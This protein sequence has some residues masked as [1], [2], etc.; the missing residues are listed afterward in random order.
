MARRPTSPAKASPTRSRSL[1][2]SGLMLEHVGRLD[3]AQR[4]RSAIDDVIIKDNMRTGDMGGRAS[5]REFAQAI[6]RRIG[7]LS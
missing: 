6:V 7:S 3:L 5:T 2:A 1:L 4:L